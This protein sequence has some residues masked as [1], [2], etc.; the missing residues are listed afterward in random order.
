M[1]WHKNDFDSFCFV[2]WKA[3]LYIYI[4]IFIIKQVVDHYISPWW[5]S[6]MNPDNGLSPDYLVDGI[7][8]IN[9]LYCHQN[10]HN[11]VHHKNFNSEKE[12]SSNDALQQGFD[13]PP[14]LLEEI[15]TQKFASTLS[16]QKGLSPWMS[17]SSDQ[18]VLRRCR[19]IL[20]AL[21]LSL[22]FI[23]LW[24]NNIPLPP[25]K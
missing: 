20:N 11:H 19:C 8:I 21:K 18:H 3:C 16:K 24:T 23:K 15:Y 2:C 14:I 13:P 9:I 5:R 6:T 1:K 25:K 12:F 22:P 7:Q 17:A 4:Y 10:H